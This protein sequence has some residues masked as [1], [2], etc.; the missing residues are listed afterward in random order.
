MNRQE[1]EAEC[2]ELFGK[3]YTEVHQFLDQFAGRPE[4]GMRHRCKLHHN[5]GIAM[6]RSLYGDEA[7]DAARLHIESDLQQEGWHCT[8]PFPENEQ[9]YKELGFF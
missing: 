4:C 6:V 9:H 3:P 8:D 1:H 5:A 2:I 7:A